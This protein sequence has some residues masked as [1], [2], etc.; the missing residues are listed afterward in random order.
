MLENNFLKG[1]MYLFKGFTDIFQ[2]RIKR[3]LIIPLIINILIFGFV[4]Y[5]GF[6]NALKALGKISFYSLPD[7]LHWLSVIITIIKFF[8]MIMVS[9]ALLSSYGVIST[10]AANLLGCPFNSI[11]STHLSRKLKYHP[12]PSPPIMHTLLREGHKLLYYLPRGLVVAILAVALHFIPP[13]NLLTPFLLYGFS[14]WM[15]AIQYLDYPADNFHVPFEDLLKMLKKHRGLTL[16][17]GLTVALLSSIPFLNLFVMPA[18]VLGS[19]RM[20]HD[21]MHKQ[22]LALPSHE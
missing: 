6:Y 9:F 11:L 4:F 22:K 5:F 18:A 3:F 13:S 15:M 12:P 2:P 16:G 19:T 14:A 17:F 20:W 7:W 21:K 1:S 8:V 10:L